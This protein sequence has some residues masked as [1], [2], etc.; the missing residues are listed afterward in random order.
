MK[1]GYV[2]SSFQL[3]NVIMIDSNQLNKFWM[4]CSSINQKGMHDYLDILE[5]LTF[6]CSAKTLLK[7]QIIS[8]FLHPCLIYFFPNL[9]NVN[10]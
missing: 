7:N 5:L 4:S 3:I 9:S 10:F 1:G 8:F 2:C 6:I